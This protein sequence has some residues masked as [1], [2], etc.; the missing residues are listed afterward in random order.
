MSTGNRAS[1]EILDVV[2]VGT[3][4][5]ALGAMLALVN[6][7][8]VPTVVDVGRRLTADLE[9]VRARMASVSPERWD[10]DD[11]GLLARNE[12]ASRTGV[13]R[14]LVMG[15]DHFYA[16]AEHLPPHSF[17][18]G[19][20]SAGWG[21]AF[22]PPR[23]EDLAGWPVPVEELLSHARRATRSLPLSEPVDALSAWFPSL[24]TG[25]GPVVELSAGQRALL[26]RIR[27]AAGRS[28]LERASVGQSRLF[29]SVAGGGAPEGDEC[30]RCGYCMYGCVYGS[31][32]SAGD[33]ILKLAAEG[34]VD[35]RLGRRVIGFSEHADHVELTTVDTAGRPAETLR[36]GRLLLGAGAVE[37]AR[38]VARSLAPHVRSL[39]LLR[40]GGA[41]L[42]LASLRRLP[43][44]WPSTNTQ[45]SVF[46]EIMDRDI[47]PNWI[48]TQI[49]P[50]N[51]LVLRKLQLHGHGRDARRARLRWAGF[52]RLAY[53]L[54]NLHSDYGSH[55]VVT[56][57]DG[58]Q[59]GAVSTQMIYPE[60]RRRHVRRATSAVREVLRSAG[61][62]SIRPLEQDSADGI[63][64]HL[65]GSLPMRS[66]P[67]V[68]TETD[69]AGRPYGSDR[70]H[71]VDASVLPSLPGTTLGL[72]ILA[73]A[74]RIAS[75]LSDAA[76]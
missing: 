74:H 49:S 25:P 34:R 67:T 70:V 69:S 38:I 4:L 76:E 14:K 59:S 53:A 42:P 30:R 48:H 18:L 26:E 28:G 15:S 50:A 75:M 35:L 40:T 63:G 44:D 27:D 23:Q 10:P 24:R 29:T 11:V 36:T 66:E 21:G 46:L 5:G 57:K 68:P 1:G 54:V 51:E 56:L 16:E 37:S 8:R 3:G 43:S 33:V 64:Y 22:L 2:V 17:G 65:G 19:G 12:T 31:I 6:A 32:L 72:L 39:R 52:E 45:S 13:P 55:Y 62:F 73:N 41:V 61:L 58:M 47:S 71:V 9:T 7:G 60:E 20:F